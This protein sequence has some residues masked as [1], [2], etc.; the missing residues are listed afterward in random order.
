MNQYLGQ[1]PLRVIS[2]AGL[3][4]VCFLAGAGAQAQQ[5]IQWGLKLQN[6]NDPIPTTVVT[7]GD[8]S[9]S[10][11]A[12]GGDTYG[13]PDSFA[14]AWQQVTGDFDIRVQVVNVTATDPLGQ[15]SP[16]GSLMVRSSLDAGAYDFMINALPLAPSG[17][18]GQIETIGRINLATDTDDL[19]GRGQNYG[20]G[21]GVPSY[22]GDTT[23]HEY[24]TYPNLWLR[25]QRQGERLLSYFA[26]ANTEDVPPGYNANPGFTNG[27]QLLGVVHGGT[28][29]PKTLY[30]GLSTVAHN[31]N[32]ND[33]T[34]TVTSTYA[35][36]GPTPTPAS[37]PNVSGTP[38]LPGTG[39]GAYPNQMVLAAIFDCAIPANG[40]GYP[41]NIVQSNQGPAQPIVWDS[42]GYTSV[43]RDIIA[44]IPYQSPGAF[45]AARYQSSGFDFALNPGNPVAALS[46]LGDYSN[47]SRCRYTMGETNVAASQA[48]IP[49]PVY[50]FV[51]DTI[52]KNG[53]Q[54]NDTTTNFY[55][56]A[57]VQLD[58]A[59]TGEGYDMISGQFHGGQFY[60]RTTKLVNGPLTNPNAGDN[61]TPYRCTI[62]HSIA[63]FPYD[64]GWKAGFFDGP[65]F[66]GSYPGTPYWKW[67]NGYGLNSGTAL[68]GLSNQASQALYNAPNNLL[69]W[70]DQP[71]GSG[72]F[73]GLATL[74]IPNVSSTNDGMLF[75]IGN[76]E[77]GGDRGP[78]AQNA[79]L[80][81][82][83]GWYV[84]VRDIENS[85]AD[86]TV[87]ATGVGEDSGASFSFLYLPFDAD[88]LIG[89]HIA[90]NGAT[91][92]G[93]GNFTVTHLST[94]RYAITI[95]G[96]TGTNGV[97]LLQDTGYLAVQPDGMTNV[98]DNSYLSYEYGGT[99]T[100]ANAF[101][102]ES[103]FVSP[104]G[105]S[106]DGVVGFR[107]A[108][109]NF[110]YVDF[111]NPVAPPGT[112]PPVLKVTHG[113]GNTVVVSWTNGPG[114]ILQKATSV[115][116]TVTWT[117]I[118]PGNP[119]APITAAGSQTF[120]RVR[121]P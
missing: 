12:G 80:P 56:A 96:V 71:L 1:R 60:T 17:R 5:P 76:D 51:Y 58:A 63:W 31:S 61:G 83:S 49:S 47:P 38:A 112:L 28:N 32:I 30:V 9:L 50:G 107:D 25:V 14:F 79:A 78:A 16:K 59:A 6:I 102:V 35:N 75:T 53:Q 113:T 11:T 86:P 110:I 67:G 40:M 117:D 57:Y 72:N 115:A 24:C 85:K 94:G 89:G 82:G 45:C 95:P 41:G 106:D 70:L 69:T 22:E 42:G 114:F 120:F 119:S 101:I 118:G 121:H 81:D 19:P 64:Q 8:G 73:V 98:V 66:N 29:F 104:P 93:A 52:N 39:P 62:R 7:N 44:N 68:A 90:T 10:I 84:A 74:T 105:P 91:I 54:W 26:T 77:S 15:D 109:F 108:E 20:P 88:N 100:P 34:H 48:W 97:L 3:S 36:Y 92:K 27:W 99:N 2:L 13:A 46:N 55:G 4:A 103:H 111:L 65:N 116:G 21:N 43:G 33:T 87:Y 23:D 37:V 18:D